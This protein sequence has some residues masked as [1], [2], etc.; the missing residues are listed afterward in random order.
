MRKNNQGLKNEKNSQKHIEQ[1][2]DSSKDK[3]PTTQKNAGQPS[4]ES[5][6]PLDNDPYYEQ[7]IIKKAE[8]EFSLKVAP[9][10]GQSPRSLKRFVNSYRL[11][12]VGLTELQW[13]VYFTDIHPKT[14]R[15]GLQGTVQNYQAVMFLLALITGMPSASRLFFRTLRTQ[16]VGSMIELLNK[17]DVTKEDN[18]WKIFGIPAKQLTQK[19]QVDKKASP[20]NENSTTNVDSEIQ[21]YNM[22]LELRQFINWLDEL[23]SVIWMDVDLEQLRYWDPYVSR[24][25]FRIEPIDIEYG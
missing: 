5:A 9:I 23:G 14:G 7:F 1:K 11:I 22:Q 20:L 13:S 4:N 10:L 18:D 6:Y 24:Y 16:T 8:N 19:K 12:K 21:L 17:I 25:S 15:R 3:T 2:I